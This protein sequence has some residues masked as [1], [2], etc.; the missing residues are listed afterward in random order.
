MKNV[1]LI[2]G[3]SGGIGME[4]ARI[5][6]R[7]GGDLVLVARSEEKLHAL[8]AE[9]K[10]KHGAEIRVFPADLSRPEAV[11]QL[12]AELTDAGVK[13]DIL[14]NNAGFGDYGLF[15]QTDWQK[16]GEMIDLNVRALTHLTRLILPGMVSRG[17]GRIM[18]LASTASFQPG[19]LMAVY[20]ATKHYVLA[21]SRALSQELAGSGVSVTALC[22]GPTASG[23][24]D[25]ATIQNS[26]IVKGKKLPGAAEV[27]AY[28]YRKMLSGKRVAIH[29]FGNR[30]MAHAVRFMP[31]RLVTAAVQ[32]MQEEK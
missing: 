24:Q 27:A 8:A 13:T 2:T 7:S 22:P 21:F 17:H 32:K 18:N 25:A 14:I 12:V 26:R 20:F 6:A 10:D 5:H 4:L 1:A 16:N 23:F 15:H 11:P 19:P 31:G 28:G 3:A 9:L 29:G 30:L